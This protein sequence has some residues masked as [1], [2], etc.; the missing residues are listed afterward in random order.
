MLNIIRYCY[1]GVNR[2]HGAL[3]IMLCTMVKYTLYIKLRILLFIFTNV[4]HT[5]RLLLQVAY[6]GFAFIIYRYE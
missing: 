6:I 1:V 3:C 4:E 2:Y 5:Y